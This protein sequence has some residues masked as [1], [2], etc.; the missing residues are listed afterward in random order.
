MRV[1]SGARAKGALESVPTNSV[2][3][4]LIPR[5]I[6]RLWLGP[7]AIP[8][9]FE[10]YEDSWR[11]HHPTWELRLWRE[12]TLPVLSCQDLWEQQGLKRRID[13]AKLEILRQCGGVFIDMDVEAIRPLDPLLPGV[14]AFLGRYAHHH[15]GQQVLGAVPHHPFFERTVERLASTIGRA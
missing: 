11:K 1:Q 10:Y 6:H 15:V 9:I 12:D 7:N 3:E 5:V 8:P 14:T 4:Q 13:I 2:K